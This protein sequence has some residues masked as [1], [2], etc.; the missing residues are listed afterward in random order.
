MYM[1]Q[2]TLQDADNTRRAKVFSQATPFASL[3]GVEFY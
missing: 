2:E 1:E 3:S